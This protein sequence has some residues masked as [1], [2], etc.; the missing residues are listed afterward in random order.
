MGVIGLAPGHDKNSLMY[1]LFDKNVI[2]SQV[3]SI[4]LDDDVPDIIF[5]ELDYSKV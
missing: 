3:V 2:E 1:S 5:G 4:S